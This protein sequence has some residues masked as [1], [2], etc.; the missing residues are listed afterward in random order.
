MSKPGLF[1]NPD[2][3]PKTFVHWDNGKVVLLP[4]PTTL[5][6]TRLEL[7][8]LI[9]TWRITSHI[10]KTENERWTVLIE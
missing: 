2:G 10:P 6:V 4:R 5:P 7:T 1:L 9:T 3:Y 8:Q